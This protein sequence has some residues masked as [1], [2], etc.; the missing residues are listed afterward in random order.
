M[1]STYS[2]CPYP[3]CAFVTS[4]SAESQFTTDANCLY[5]SFIFATYYQDGTDISVLTPLL[6]IIL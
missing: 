1:F 5:I 2:P 6:S 4:V 3:L